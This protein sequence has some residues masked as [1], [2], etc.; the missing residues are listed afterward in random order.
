MSITGRRLVAAFG[1]WLGILLAL[2]L[3]PTPAH[4]VESAP[5]AIDEGQ[6]VEINGVE[7]WVTVRGRTAGNPVLLILHGGPGFPMSVLAPL[8]KEWEA[9]FTIVQWDQPATGGTFLKNKNRDIGPLT[10]GRYVNDGIAVTEWARKRLGADKVVLLGTSWGSLL[11]IEMVAKRPD[12]FSAYVGTSQPVGSKGNLLGY[13]LG[14]K[15]ARE[16]GDK[17]AVTALTKVGPPPYSRFEDF[18]VRAQ[19][20]NPP[21]VPSTPAEAAASAAMMGVL[22]TPEPN[23]RYNSPLPV[24]AGFDGGFMAAQQATWRETWSW[25]IEGLGKKFGVP[26][27]IFQGEADLNT[28]AAPAREWLE[29]VEAPRKAFEIVPGAGH[30]VILFHRELLKLLE[31]HVLPAVAAKRA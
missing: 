8:Y 25:E 9:K 20:T 1:A 28:P 2:S 14:L 19:Y 31:K 12:L 10:I 11:G 7:Q 26:L 22:M 27:F 6:F 17:A 24:P 16:R 18:M 4:A 30:G 5:L 15:S 23:A 13:E 21:A 3:L 29:A